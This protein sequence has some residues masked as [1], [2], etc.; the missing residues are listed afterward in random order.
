[1]KTFAKSLSLFQ[2]I[3]LKQHRVHG[4][5]RLVNYGKLCICACTWVG[6]D[7]AVSVGV[8]CVTMGVSECGWVWV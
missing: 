2:N 4:N 7:K 6:V 1:M 8:R 5:V 3:S